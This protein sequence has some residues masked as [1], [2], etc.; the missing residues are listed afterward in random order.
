MATDWVCRYARALGASSDDK[1]PEYSV[2]ASFAA[3]HG[4]QQLRRFEELLREATVH[5]PDMHAEGLQIIEI[6]RRLLGESA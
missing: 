5:A 4:E 1:T 6:L 2:I 3:S